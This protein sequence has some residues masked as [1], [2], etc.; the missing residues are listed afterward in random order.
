VSHD[1]ENFNRENFHSCCDL[2]ASGHQHFQ[3]ILSQH[4]Y[5]PF[6]SRKPGFETLIHIILEQQVSLASALAAYKKLK[7]VLHEVTPAL[8]MQLTDD[9][10]KACYFSRQKIIY[11]RDLAQHILKGNINFD[12][13]IRMDNESI[14]SAL[15]QVKGIG[16]WT[17]N[18]FLMMSLH[19]A[20]IFPLNDIA[21]I[22]SI[23]HE[24]KTEM[25]VT[26]ELL[27]TLSGQWSPYR[28]IAAYFLWHAYLSRRQKVYKQ[29][30]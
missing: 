8:F 5:P 16:H 2:L 19:R 1:P 25:P 17:A 30:Y 10:L 24:L 15:Q 4:G 21:L 3:N 12:E 29:K 7:Q 18:I 23:R 11:S 27:L 26:K 6:W 13:M 28:T 22:S 20:D 9:E 14:S